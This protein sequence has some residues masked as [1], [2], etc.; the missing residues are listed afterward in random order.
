MNKYFLVLSGIILAV[1]GLGGYIYWQ[2][3]K[4]AAWLLYDRPIRYDKQGFHDS[5]GHCDKLV[6]RRGG[7][8]CCAGGA[9]GPVLLTITNKVEIADF[10]TH[11]RFAP[12][13][14]TN[15]MMESCMCCG[16]PGIDFYAGQRLLAITAVQHME[17]LRWRGFSTARI[18]TKRVGYGD[19]PLTTDSRRWLTNW[20]LKH[21]LPLDELTKTNA[22][23]KS[24]ER[25]AAEQIS[26][27]AIAD[28]GRRSALR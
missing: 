1:V 17:N 28:G 24:L 25:T 21:S 26:F 7:F 4:L 11:L 22:A 23:N 9:T 10:L 3:G 16:F 6:V 12:L 14:T 15:S 27:A 18:L 19:A 20:F 8:D 5:L 13:G 2:N